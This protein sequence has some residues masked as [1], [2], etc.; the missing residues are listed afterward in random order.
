MVNL[1][2]LFVL[3]GMVDKDK[4]MKKVQVI[5]SEDFKIGETLRKW[6]ERPAGAWITEIPGGGAV[7]SYIDVFIRFKNTQLEVE[8]CKSNKAI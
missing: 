8:T 5:Y 6:L 1:V 3:C 2:T 7:K 4:N